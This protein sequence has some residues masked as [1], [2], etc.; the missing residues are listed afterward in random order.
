MIGALSDA[1]LAANSLCLSRHDPESMDAGEALSHLVAPQLTAPFIEKVERLA[2]VEEWLSESDS[3][4]SD[5]F[6]RLVRETAERHVERMGEEAADAPVV[7][8]KQHPPGNT[9]R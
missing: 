1:Y 6:A 5:A 3:P 8:P 2:F 7:P 4:D 9:R